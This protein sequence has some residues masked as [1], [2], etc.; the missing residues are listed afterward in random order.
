MDVYKTSYGFGAFLHFYY[1]T[2]IRLKVFDEIEA[3]INDHRFGEFDMK[4][5]SNIDRR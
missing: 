1:Q 5:E 3:C 2:L 4:V